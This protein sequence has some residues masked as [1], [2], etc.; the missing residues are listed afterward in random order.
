M[1]ILIRIFKAAFMCCVS[2]F[3]IDAIKIAKEEYKQAE[4]E[5]Q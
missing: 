1:V 2:Q 4:K 5:E 3:F